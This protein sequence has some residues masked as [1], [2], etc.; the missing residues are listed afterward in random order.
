MIVLRIIVWKLLCDIPNNDTPRKHYSN[1]F[2]YTFQTATVQEVQ[3]LPKRLIC[4]IMKKVK[5][6]Y[7]TIITDDEVHFF[8]RII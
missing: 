8:P 2:R 6:N 5:R 4:R 1:R 3:K 7:N